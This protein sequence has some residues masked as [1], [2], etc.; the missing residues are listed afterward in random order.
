MAISNRWVV[1]AP[2][3]LWVA[4]VAEANPD[5]TTVAVGA[6]WGGNWAD[7][8]DFA[9]GQE[10]EVM[11]NDTYAKVYGARSNVLKIQART[12]REAV[13]KGTLQ[14][15]SIA[16]WAYLLD[17]TADAAVAAGA[18]QKGYQEL[19]FGINTSVSTYKWGIEAYKADTAGILQPIRWFFHIG[20]IRMAASTKYATGTE[21]QMGFEVD[22]YG[23]TSQSAGEELGILQ[24]VS[25]AATA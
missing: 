13:I 23:D 20:A 24:L 19:P 21:A 7:M 2:G 4:P 25:A 11:L 16:N 22:V 5:E 6:A 12:R 14:E 10:I 1:L 18:S 17:A 3:S 15:H 8:G 9:E